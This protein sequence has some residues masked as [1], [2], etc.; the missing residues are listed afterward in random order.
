MERKKFFFFLSSRLAFFLLF[1]SGVALNLY[2]EMDQT[3]VKQQNW[4]KGQWLREQG[5]YEESLKILEEEIHSKYS[6]DKTLEKAICW[7]NIGLDYWNLG[8]VD[9]AQNSFSFLLA[10]LKDRPN[11]AIREYAIAAIDIIKL[12]KEAKARRREQKYQE[13]E[14]LFLKAIQIAQK[15]GMK[16]LEL[17]NLRQISFIYLYPNLY[18]LEDF[19]KVSNQSLKIATELNHYFEICCALNQLGFYY[20]KKNDYRKAY[21]LFYSAAYLAEVKGQLNKIPESLDNLGTISYYFGNYDLSGGYFKK[22]IKIYEKEGDIKNIVIDLLELALN[23][24]K[25]QKVNKSELDI[26]E[27]V[28][29]MLTALEYARRM[30]LEEF[31]SIILNDIGY[32]YL[33]TDLKKAQGFIK[34][35][36][37]KAISINNKRGIAASLNNLGTIYFRRNKIDE[38]MKNY[39]QSLSIALKIDYWPEIWNDYAGLGQCYEKLGNYEMALN[40]YQKAL[41]TIGKIR[42]TIDLDFNKISFDRE[43]KLVYEGIIRCLVLLKEKNKP[44]A[45]FNESIFAFMHR[46]KAIAFQEGLAQMSDEEQSQSLADELSRTDHQI[47]KIIADAENTQNE[48]F[49]NRLLELEYRY[50]QMLG[51]ENNAKKNGQEESDN[52]LSLNSFQ[53]EAI[54]N[55]QVLLD[56]YLGEEESYCF[57]IGRDTYQIIKLPSEKEIENSIKLYIKLL[58]DTSIEEQDLFCP[59]FRIASLLIPPL[60]NLVGRVTSLTIIPDG[61]LNY[62]PF[63][64]LVLEDPGD[65]GRKK[66]LVEKFRISYAPSIAA[67]YKFK[68]LPGHNGYRKELLAFGNPYYDSKEQ[69]RVRSMAFFLNGQRAGDKFNLPALP[70]SQEEVKEIGRLFLRS[71]YDLFVKKKAT[72]DN[73]KRLNLTNYRILHFACHGLISENYPQR[74]C[75]VF[76]LLPGT[77][78]DGFLTVREIYNLKLK[79]ELVV[80]SACETSR[81]AMEKAEGII[82]LPRVFLLSGSQAV[83]S[84]LWSVNDRATQELMKDFYQF[85][86]AGDSKDEALRKAKLKMIRSGK[87]HPYYWAG[88]ILTGNSGKIY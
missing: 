73:L 20:S 76:S 78:E 1:F 29:T 66:Y 5:R 9:K 55:D 84:S 22:A 19:Y 52:H 23:N 59:G 65:A 88:F 38:A 83:V 16:E 70:Y 10:L 6:E 17:K 71:K 12:Y 33:E 35:A 39:Q 27:P 69:K 74:S 79:A 49:S 57:L 44:G 81:G 43:K 45:D 60:K 40:A 54:N 24:Y 7:Q 64:S 68:K 26:N 47:S 28:S 75:L 86:L 30:S 56:Y 21:R 3:Q 25:K 41:E 51:E 77:K 85:L 53:N 8:E 13:S 48:E 2:R 80:L 15:N 58:S 14:Q 82:G 72:E 11:D 32:I 18:R 87:S 63:E 67:F 37:E 62:L 36:W 61:L 34:E 46:V 31:E 4:Q 50:L 42:E